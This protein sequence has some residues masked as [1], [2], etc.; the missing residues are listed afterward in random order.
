MKTTS[1]TDLMH[2][3]PSDDGSPATPG[4]CNVSRT[5]RLDALDAKYDA[6]IKA[7]G[8]Y[9]GVLR[10]YDIKRAQE[11]E[12]RYRFVELECELAEA[13]KHRDEERA[14]YLNAS[15]ERDELRKSISEA[16]SERDEMNQTLAIIYEQASKTLLTSSPNIADWIDDVETIGLLASNED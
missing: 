11:A 8:E 1:T 12:I 5:P 14:A 3:S 15:R 9:P 7:L 6:E 2:H 13:I 10:I 4:A 16:S